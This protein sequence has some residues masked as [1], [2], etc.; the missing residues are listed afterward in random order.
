[1]S[2]IVNKK[3]SWNISTIKKEDNSALKDVNIFYWDNNN[4]F[5]Q[6][7]TDSNGNT[8]CIKIQPQEILKILKV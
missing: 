4:N 6:L 8:S 2:G 7:L 3:F 5:N 1:M